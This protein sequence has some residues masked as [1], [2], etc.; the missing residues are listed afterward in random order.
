VLEGKPQTVDIPELA[1][2]RVLPTLDQVI[3]AVCRYYEIDEDTI[4]QQTRGK[5][6]ISSARSV[7]MYMCQRAAGMKLAEIAEA[8]GLASYASAGATIRQ[9]KAKRVRDKSLE[10]SINYILLDLRF[11]Q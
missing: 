8:F 4:W 3:K 10:E 5:G 1:K 11:P 7:A 2:E 9:V 6:V